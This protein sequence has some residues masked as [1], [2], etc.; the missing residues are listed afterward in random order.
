M[1]VLGALK[2][3]WF[4]VLLA[5]ADRPLHGYGIRQ[6]VAERT[7]GTIKL[8]PG[9]LYRSIKALTEKGWLAEVDPPGDA[10]EDA[11]DRR[12]YAITPTG[13]E[14]LAAETAR[15]SAYVAAARDKQ[16]PFRHV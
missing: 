9:V 10:P 3:H 2:S 12:Y 15:M 8:W 14:A 4:H 5:I 7:E 11:R 16:V 13:L 6:E 1:P